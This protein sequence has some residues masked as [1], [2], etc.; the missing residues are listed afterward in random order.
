MASGIRR[1]TMTL[2]TQYVLVQA[3]NYANRMSTQLKVQLTDEIYV[4]QPNLLAYIMQR[5]TATLKFS[6][7]GP[8]ELVEQMITNF[9]VDHPERYLLAFVHGH[10]GQHDLLRV[11]TDA[12]KYLLLTCLN[13]VEKHIFGNQ[14][15]LARRP[16]HR[17]PNRQSPL[18]RSGFGSGASPG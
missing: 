16:A 6:G 15:R 18:A 3:N 12:E 5:L 7:G 9:C 13:L 8:P 17:P 14:T 11:R 2:L 4:L 1:G 10:L